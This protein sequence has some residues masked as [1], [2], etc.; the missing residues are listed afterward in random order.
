MMNTGNVTIT[1]LVVT[2]VI[3]TA[4]LVGTYLQTSQPVLAEGPARSGNYICVTG[5]WNVNVNIAW[6]INI[7]S[8]Q[9]NI[10]YA[11]HKTGAIELI[12]TVD[13]EQAFSF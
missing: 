4:M 1:I 2:A 10:Y 6:V 3:L 13:L 9:L 7:A 5:R 11:N 8:R 12:D